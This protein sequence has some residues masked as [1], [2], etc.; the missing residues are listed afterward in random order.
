MGYS[1]SYELH[2]EPAV[3][4]PIWSDVVSELRQFSEG[5]RYALDEDGDTYESCKWY[6]HEVDLSDF[7]K[8]HPELRF[9]LHGEGE[10]TGD[11]W[12]KHFVEGQICRCKAEI[13]IPEYNEINLVEFK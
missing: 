7:S 11:I 6:D 10:E 13:V 9:I 3:S 2:S 8:T 1:T 4:F 12:A 5:A